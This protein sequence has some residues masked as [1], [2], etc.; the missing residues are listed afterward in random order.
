MS[1]SLCV[2]LPMSGC[3]SW[4]PNTVLVR[5]FFVLPRLPPFPHCLTNYFPPP[6]DV[7]PLPFSPLPNVLLPVFLP[8][9]ADASDARPVRLRAAPCPNGVPDSVPSTVP[10]PAPR[11][12]DASC[13]SQHASTWVS[14]ASRYVRACVLPFLRIA[15]FT[16]GNNQ[17]VRVYERRRI[18]MCDMTA[19]VSI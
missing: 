9:D 10:L 17:P 8:R 1:I 5:T 16:H 13:L 18:T 11:W 2:Y 7:T 15:T 14:G 19:K 3:V 4:F 6:S 12:M